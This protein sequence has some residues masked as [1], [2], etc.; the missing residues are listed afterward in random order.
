MFNIIM[1]NK[2]NQKNGK[3]EKKS[4][5]GPPKKV[6]TSSGKDLK[7]KIQKLKKKK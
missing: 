7:L 2:I 5:S 1:E 4:E 3:H 6:L